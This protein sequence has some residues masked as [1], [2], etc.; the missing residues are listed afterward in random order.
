[1]NFPVNATILDIVFIVFTLLMLIIGYLKGFV[2]RLYDFLAMI[3]A[4]LLSMF[5]SGPISELIQLYTTDGIMAI[6][7]MFINRMFVFGILFSIFR[8]VFFLIGKFVKPTLKA[9]VSKISLIQKF[10]QV[11]GVVLSFIEVLIIS[12]IILLISVSPIFNDGKEVVNDTVVAKQVLKIAPS[13]SDQVMKMTDDF[14]LINDIIDQGVNYD[15]GSPESVSLMLSMLS[16]IDNFDLLPQ[17]QID[18]LVGGYMDTLDQVDGQIVVDKETYET[19]QELVDK[20][21]SSKIDKNKIYEKI[22]RE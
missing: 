12:Y 19:L 8:L 4:L 5:L 16:G 13:L 17:D 7:G 6:I 15:Y 11:L 3:V 22:T 14:R 10:D 20:I 1:M 18:E 21:D 2:V 9:A